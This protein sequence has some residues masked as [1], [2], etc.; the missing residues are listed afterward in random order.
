MAELVEE[1]FDLVLILSVIKTPKLPLSYTRK[2]S[3]FTHMVDGNK[4]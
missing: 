3:L 2:R 1:P 4:P